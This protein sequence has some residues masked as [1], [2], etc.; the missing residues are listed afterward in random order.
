LQPSIREAQPDDYRSIWELIKNDLGYPQTDFEKLCH[1]LDLM[2][3]ED[4]HQTV[5]A[6]A[7]GEVVGFMGMYR[8]IAYNYDGDYL[9]IVAL[10]VAGE[11]Q[12]TGIGTQLLGWAER[13]AL[14]NDIH[15]IVLTSR[16]H[17]VEAHAF[18]ERKGYVKG[19]YGFRKDIDASPTDD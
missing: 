16:L 19:S 3:A 12:N 2:K 11:K 10:A 18:Y 6:V 15:A 9:Q 14:K 5:V 1:R 17:R 8:Y 13:Y 7:G 4:R